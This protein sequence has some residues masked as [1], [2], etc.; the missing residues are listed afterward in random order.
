MKEEP[1]NTNEETDSTEDEVFDEDP[2]Q[3]ERSVSRRW[4]YDDDDSPSFERIK[5][6]KPRKEEA[7]RR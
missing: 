5:R 7:D 3:S 4:D 6:K 1:I 2:V